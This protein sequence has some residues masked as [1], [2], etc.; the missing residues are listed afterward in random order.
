MI[1]ENPLLQK[2]TPYHIIE[3]IPLLIKEAPYYGRT[4]FPYYRNN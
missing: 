1:E 3:I 4:T 2:E